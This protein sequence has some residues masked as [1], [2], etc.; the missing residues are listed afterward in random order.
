MPPGTLLVLFT[1]GLVEDRR[2]DLDVGLDLVRAQVESCDPGDLPGL[3]ATLLATAAE[4]ED[5]VALLLVRA[6]GAL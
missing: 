3:A 1:D 4:E 5:D 6:Q 2:R